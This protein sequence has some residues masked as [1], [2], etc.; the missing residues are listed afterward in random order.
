[1][2]KS[3]R[4]DE[5]WAVTTVTTVDEIGDQRERARDQREETCGTVARDCPNCDAHARA[6]P[7]SPTRQAP[8]GRCS[9][10]AYF[11]VL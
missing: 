1:M 8:G 3:E 4:V 5:A 2:K 11:T 10:P 6:P 9:F 7:K